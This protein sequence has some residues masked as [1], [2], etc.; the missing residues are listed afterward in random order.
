[1]F[2]TYSKTKMNIII[3]L[4]FASVDKILH[5]TKMSQAVLLQSHF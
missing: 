4:G 1:M 2:S 3:G 5:S